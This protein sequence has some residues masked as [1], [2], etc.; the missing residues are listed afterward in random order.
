VQA[1]EVERTPD[2]ERVR[3]LLTVPVEEVATYGFVVGYSRV[4]MARLSDP[5]PFESLRG[6]NLDHTEDAL[7]AATADYENAT[8]VTEDRRLRGRATSRAST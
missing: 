6:G 3:R 1:D 8:L 2:R 4:G 5:E 7:I